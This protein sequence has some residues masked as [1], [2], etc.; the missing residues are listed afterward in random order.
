MSDSYIDVEQVRGYEFEPSVFEYNEHAVSLYALGVGAASDP[1][2]ESD[3]R[4]VYELHPDGM[5]VLPTMAVIFPFSAIGT[6]FNMP[7]L[8]FQPMMLLHGE[9]YLEIKQP[10]TTHA[11]L[12]N[13]AHISNVYDKGSGVLILIDAHS[14]DEA[15]NE[16]A[17]NQSSIFI[18]SL[19]G[20]G[21]ERG[22][23]SSANVPPERPPDAIHKEQT[24]PDQALLYRL[25]GDHNPLHADPGMAAQGGFARPILHGLATFGFGG[26]AVLKHFCDNDPTRLQS[27]KVRFTKHVFPGETLVTE[28]WHEP[29]KQ[30]VLFQMKVA[31]RDEVVISNAAVELKDNS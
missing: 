27:I 21:G 14:F 18:R 16:V 29:E 8:Q 5:L 24:R 25:S 3:L 11:R 2:D 13:R 23:S 10:L 30:R 9:Q 12:T 31:E 26:R 7:G 22:A 6:I 19:G 20:F 1:L 15:G 4:F 28:M 17:F